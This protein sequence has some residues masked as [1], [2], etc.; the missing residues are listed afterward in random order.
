MTTLLVICGI[1]IFIIWL[2]KSNEPDNSSTNSFDGDEDSSSYSSLSDGTSA[3]SSC[4]WCGYSTCSG[5]LG[6]MNSSNPLSG[7]HD[8]SSNSFEHSASDDSQDSLS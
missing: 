3:T 4:S 7:L 6:C 1:G 2:Y 8:D 5:G